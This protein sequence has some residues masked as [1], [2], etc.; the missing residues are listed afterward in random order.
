MMNMMVKPSR[1]FAHDD[2]VADSCV[3]VRLIL[4]NLNNCKKTT[5]RTISQVRY[6]K[7]E[8]YNDPVRRPLAYL[9]YYRPTVSPASA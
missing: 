9:L 7:Y 8:R 2:I 5:K 6:N 3:I 1:S 4:I